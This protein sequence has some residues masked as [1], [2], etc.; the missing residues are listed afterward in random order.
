ME[1]NYELILAVVNRGFADEV[2]SAATASGARGGTVMHGRGTSRVTETIYGVPIEPEKDVVMMMVAK[3]KCKAIMQN[4]YEK[5]GLN[6]HGSG[7]CFALPVDE[8]VG[9]K[10]Y[11]KTSETKSE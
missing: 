7:I 8:V 2:V 4:I 3:D 1:N 10:D 6:S 11:S 5:V 9:L